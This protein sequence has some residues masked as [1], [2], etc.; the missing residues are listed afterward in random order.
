MAIQDLTPAG[1]SVS[2]VITKNLYIKDTWLVSPSGHGDVDNIQNA[3]GQTSTL[4]GPLPL[5]GAG[6]AF[7]FS[8]RIRSGIKGAR[9]V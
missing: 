4:P 2:R 9:L 3:C 8:R 7:G 5:L 6:A 1:I